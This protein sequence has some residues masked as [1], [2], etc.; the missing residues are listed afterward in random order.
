MPTMYTIEEH[1]AQQ[2]KPYIDAKI[3][4][5]GNVS[6]DP[7]TVSYADIVSIKDGAGV[8][9]KDVSIKIEPVQAGSGTPSPTNVRAI[10]G[11][12][13]VT[14]TRCGKNLV[15][16]SVTELGGIDV[17]GNYVDSESASL[18]RMKQNAFIN[19]QPNE[20]YSCRWTEIGQ[21]PLSVFRIYYYD[22]DKNYLYR[23][24]FG[25]EYVKIFTIPSNAY[26]IKWTTYTVE[27]HVTLDI[28]ESYQIQI[29]IGEAAT[30]YEPYA[31]NDYTIDLGGTIYGG[32]LD[33][34]SGKLTVDRGYAEFDGSNDENWEWS[35][36]NS[37][38]SISVDNAF[39]VDNTTQ[40]NKYTLNNLFSDTSWANRTG[41]GSVGLIWGTSKIFLQYSTLG[42]TISDLKSFLTS[43]PLQVVYKLA[44][45]QVIQLTP[46]QIRMLAGVNTVY[47]NTGDT[48]VEYF[49]ASVG[50][51]GEVIGD[52][53]GTV[54]NEVTTRAQLGAHNLGKKYNGV[55]SIGITL[56]DAP[57]GGNY[58]NGTATGGGGRLNLK[59]D[60]FVLKAG[61]YSIVGES[62][63]HS[64]YS[65][66]VLQKIADNSVLGSYL[67]N[68]G[69]VDKSQATVTLAADTECYFGF[70]TSTG[71]AY[72]TDTFIIYPMVKLADDKDDT[73]YP[74]SKSNVELT[75]DISS[76]KSIVAASSDFADFKTRIANL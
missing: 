59:S 17:N 67:I 60:N 21:N 54:L 50:N 5:V 75:E 28:V 23:Q 42:S 6:G 55:T 72:G 34:T 30:A 11:R 19:V 43:N 32:T 25:T 66:V 14:V 12:S 35:G 63:D 44:T 73:F 58:V 74:Y 36:N 64:K 70:N 33:V 62:N 69:T 27:G 8:L 18:W 68:N 65:A 48:Q 52:V 47:A 9:A 51:L 16:L 71:T 45:P 37:L 76:L 61:T 24:D 41:A 40:A 2:V 57:D 49:N 26:F 38:F 31:G 22:K 15:D 3:G 39:I 20:K 7:K 4:T 1:E 53:Q 13:E 46:T 56:K 10:S 29:E